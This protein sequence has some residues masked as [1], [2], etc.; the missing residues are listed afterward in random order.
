MLNVLT[1]NY[2]GD[3]Q[4][5]HLSAAV[6]NNIPVTGFK[7]NYRSDF[8]GSIHAEISAIESLLKGTG[9]ALQPRA[10]F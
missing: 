10:H 7:Y 4:S 6:L 8:C 3:M 9:R 1:N 2:E 5:K